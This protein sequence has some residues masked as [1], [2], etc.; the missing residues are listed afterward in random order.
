MKT[1]YVYIATNKNNKVLYTGVTSNIDRR[2]LE[3]QFKIKPNSFTAKYN[4]SKIVYLESF[5]NPIDAIAAEKRIKGWT[6][7][8]KEKLINQQNPEWNN[9]AI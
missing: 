6:R 5:S 9:L 7:N 8:K 4:I 1:Y 3:H 2:I